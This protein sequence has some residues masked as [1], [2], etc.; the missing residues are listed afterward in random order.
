M[1]QAGPN[2]MSRSPIS[3]VPK[4]PCSTLFKNLIHKFVS[5]GDLPIAFQHS[6]CFFFFFLIW[7]KLT[8][9]SLSS[10]WPKSP[11]DTEIAK[12]N[13]GFFLTILSSELQIQLEEKGKTCPIQRRHL[14][15]F[16]LSCMSIGKKKHTQQKQVLSRFLE[17]K[18]GLDPGRQCLG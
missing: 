10:L 12:N 18:W 3:R 1:K 9:A 7:L 16:W 5:P 11:M 13:Q 8:R 17:A 14:A 15:G 4:L 6:C 2:I